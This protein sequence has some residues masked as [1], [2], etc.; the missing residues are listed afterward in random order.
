MGVTT[1]TSNLEYRKEL[2]CPRHIEL[3]R[4]GNDAAQP[5][6]SVSAVDGLYYM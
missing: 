2:C 3:L 5:D 4:L 1:S 6:R